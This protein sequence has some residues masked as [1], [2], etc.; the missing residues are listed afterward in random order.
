MEVVDQRSVRGPAKLPRGPYETRDVLRDDPSPVELIDRA[1]ARSTMTRATDIEQRASEWLIRSEGSRFTE[2]MQAELDRW[3]LDPVNKVTFVRIK[4]AWLRANRLRG[5]R[6]F[7]GNV[8]PDLFK[9]PSDKTESKKKNGSPWTF[10]IAT[11]AALALVVY[12]GFAIRMAVGPS[13][14]ISYTTSVGGYQQTTFIDGTTVQLNTDTMVRARVTATSRE[15]KVIRGEALIKAADA[16]G[17]PLTVFAANATAHPSLGNKGRAS[18]VVRMKATAVEFSVT[19]GSI[20]VEESPHRIIDLALNRAPTAGSTLDAG[21]VASVRPEGIH[22]ERVGLDELMR[23]QSW[24]VGDLSFQGETLAQIAD[25]F[26]RYNRR[27]LIITDPSIASRRIGG[28]FK[29]NDPDSFAAALEKFDIHADEQL[30]NAN[31]ETVIRLRQ[32]PR[33]R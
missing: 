24:V 32:K 18:F 9:G 7:D 33:S 23:K 5:F 13:D 16:P 26:N 12:L 10:R 30:P 6:P 4:N 8:D 3:L 25:E 1:G 22:F 14:F 19:D 21:D 11:T 28:V 17:R 2:E 27:Q 31:G 15:I 20:T 29:E